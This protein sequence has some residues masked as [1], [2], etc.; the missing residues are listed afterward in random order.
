MELVKINIS[1]TILKVLILICCGFAIGC[2]TSLDSQSG[3]GR[4]LY[5]A[6]GV[7]YSGNNTTFSN[8][9]STNQV[10]R[11]NLNT[12]VKEVIADYFKAPSNAGDS[13]TGL[14][15]INSNE[16]YVLV[17]NA[18]TATLRRVE[19]VR[20]A[21]D[22]QRSIFS[23]NTTALSA[24]LRAISLLANGDMLI[25]KNTA[26]EYLTAA[27]ARVGAPFISATGAPCN[28]STTIVPKILTLKNGKIVFTHATANQNRIG[29]FAT[30]GGTTCEAAQT[31]PVNASSFTTAMVYDSVNEKLLVAFAGNAATTDFNAIYS[32]NINETVPSF[33]SPQKVYDLAQYPGIYPNLLYGI[34]AMAYDSA[35]GHIYIASTI[36]T[37]TTAVNYAIY[38][39]NYNPTQIGVDNTKVLQNPSGIPFYDYGS[40]TR[41]IAD[42][43]IAD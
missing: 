12:G 43:M 10:Y 34:S 8:T 21:V 7:C 25:S 38:R 40:D 1:N 37:A 9:T 3:G 23:N 29:I 35:N 13:P 6:T 32:Y 33:S 30:T 19:R 27:N 36:T 14:A 26:I 20:K 31:A 5:V 15:N 16:I 22:G 18:T 24:P 11:L 28:T 41:C 17:E 39:F 42:M 2:N 4:Y